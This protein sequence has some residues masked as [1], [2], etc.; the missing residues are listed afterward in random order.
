MQAVSDV[1]AGPTWW[2]LL[3]ATTVHLLMRRR[4]RLAL[5]VFLPA[6]PPRWR[7][8]A[9]VVGALFALAVGVS[10]IVLG[11]HWVSD[12]IGGW[13]LSAA[14]VLAMAAIFRTWQQESGEP[15]PV[16]LADPLGQRAPSSA[17]P[18]PPG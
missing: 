5:L 13:L 17:P 14:W 2:V 1:G 18:R 11:V 8:P 4:R 3:T 7:R 9:V 15:R 10:R 16:E 12:V 6:L